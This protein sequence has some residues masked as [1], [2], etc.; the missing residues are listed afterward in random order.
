M[1]DEMDYY[2]KITTI[3][4]IEEID[5]FYKITTIMMTE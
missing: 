3:M 5:C 1:I 2:Y 4:R